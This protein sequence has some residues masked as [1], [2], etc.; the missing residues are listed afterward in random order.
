M[1]PE[2]NRPDHQLR[3]D[4]LT[5]VLVQRPVTLRPDPYGDVRGDTRSIMRAAPQVLVGN[6][7]L[8]SAEAEV[9]SSRSVFGR[10]GVRSRGR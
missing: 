1:R 4:S 7:T 6:V 3:W 9:R 2:R 8:Q 10:S 5:A